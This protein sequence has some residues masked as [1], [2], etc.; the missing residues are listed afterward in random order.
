MLREDTGYEVNFKL[1]KTF[2]V[3]QHMLH[4]RKCSTCLEK[5]VYSGAVEWNV[6]Y[7]SVRLIWYI[8]LFGFTVSLLIFC[9][10]NLSNVKS[11]IM[12][13]PIIIVL[14]FISSLSSPCS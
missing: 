10:D 8:V 5:N 7:M 14:L 2:F 12:N 13:S 9:L 1:F 11:G 4:P 3:A 6:L